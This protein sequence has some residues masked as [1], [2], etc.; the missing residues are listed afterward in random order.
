[1]DDSA[2]AVYAADGVQDAGLSVHQDHDADVRAIK[3]AHEQNLALG[4]DCAFGLAVKYCCSQSSGA[5]S[6]VQGSREG[7]GLA[8]AR[9]C[10]VS[11]FYR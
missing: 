5:Q 1:M 11:Q 6:P 3:G 4:Q 9:S 8:S 7:A 10:S 2:G